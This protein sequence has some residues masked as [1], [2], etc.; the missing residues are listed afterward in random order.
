MKASDYKDYVFLLNKD[1]QM[2]FKMY[3]SFIKYT[4]IVFN[5]TLYWECI[6]DEACSGKYNNIDECYNFIVNSP[7]H[8][9]YV[10]KLH[11]HEIK[12]LILISVIE[13][14]F[15]LNGD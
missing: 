13:Y 14:Y 10:D 15:K 6:D 8:Y 4:S 9:C 12:A 2:N 1:D 5:D 11:D 7:D 3:E